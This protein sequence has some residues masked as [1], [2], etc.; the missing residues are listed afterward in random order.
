MVTSAEK[1]KAGVVKMDALITVYVHHV[2]STSCGMRTEAW[3]NI[4]DVLASQGSYCSTGLDM[5]IDLSGILQHFVC[6]VELCSIFEGIG[7]SKVRD[8]TDN[9]DHIMNRYLGCRCFSVSQSQP[10]K[11]HLFDTTI[12]ILDYSVSEPW[13]S[14]ASYFVD[15]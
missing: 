1:S 13:A 2:G 11:S 3:T 14:E 12:G 4:L 6:G 10:Y 9:P 15:Q 8:K 5:F 7:L